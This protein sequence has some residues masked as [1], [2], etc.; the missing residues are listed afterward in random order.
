MEDRKRTRRGEL[1]AHFRSAIVWDYKG[2][3][4]SSE[5]LL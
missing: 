2:G 1:R 4:S 5:E 3:G